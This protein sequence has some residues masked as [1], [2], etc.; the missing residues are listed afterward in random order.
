LCVEHEKAG[1]YVKATV[2]DH[3]KPH[4]GDMALFWKSDNWQTLCKQC[5]DTKTA[6][7]DGAFGNPRSVSI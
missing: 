5:H 4:Q 6:R 2:V 3:I 1:Q 7:E